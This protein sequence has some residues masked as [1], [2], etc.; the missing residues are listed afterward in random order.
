MSYSGNFKA[1]LDACVLY[2]ASVRDLLLSLAD[3]ELYSPKWSAKIQEEWR[4][5]LL[6]DRPD[7]P[8]EVLQRTIDIMNLAFEDAEISDFNEIS[9]G[10]QLPDPN[11]I[12]VLAAAIK[13]RADVIVTNNLEDFPVDYISQFNIEVIHPDAFILNVI[14]L[15]PELALVALNEQ[16]ARL[17]NPPRSVDDVLGIFERNGLKKSAKRFRELYFH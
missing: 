14:D 12:H 1:V 15:D 8:P 9:K 2:P 3:H 10:L 7:I 16:V 4:Y 6:K 11:D 13:G 5:N 17:K